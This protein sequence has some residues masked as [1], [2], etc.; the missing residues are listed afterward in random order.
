M[1]VFDWGES[2]KV[3]QV[4]EPRVQRA[5][6][7]DGYEQRS[8]DGINTSA[9]VWD[10]LFDQVDPAIA[11]DLLGF[12]RARNGVEA[13]DW[14]PRWATAPIR[15]KCEKWTRSGLEDGLSQISCQFI[16][17]FEP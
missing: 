7:G 4:E 17:V 10:L 3:T 2:S 8:A 11:A 1:A 13:F 6:F 12:L 9:Q 15:V 16:Q 5:K 14:T